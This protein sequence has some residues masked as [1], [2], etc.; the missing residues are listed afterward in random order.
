MADD[1]S[2]AASEESFSGDLRRLE[3]LRRR[4]PD[5]L[6]PSLR[7]LAGRAR[8]SHNTVD[9]WLSGRTFPADVD[10]LLTVVDDIAQAAA[11]TGAAG[12]DAALLDPR[13]WREQH[14]AVNRARVREAERARRGRLAAAALAEAETRARHSALADPP[15]RLDQW[16]AARLRVHPAVSGTGTHAPGFVLP[17]YVE[18]LHDRQ[19]RDVLRTAVTGHEVVLLV[20]RGGSCT[21]KTRAAYEAVRQVCSPAGWD[22]VLP[23]TAASARELLSARA[24]VARTVLW[25][26]D[27]HHLLSGSEG[28]ALSAGLL[29][30][31][32]RPGPA[33]IMATLWDAAYTELTAPPRDFGAA[34]PRRHA[35]DLLA[36]AT[37]VVHVPPAFGPDDL[38]VLDTLGGD[39]ALTAARSSS[40][41]GKITQ[42]LA[43]GLQLVDRYES[44][45]EPPACYPRALV[46]AAMDAS[47]LGWDALLPDGFLRDAAPG[48]LTAEQRTAAGPHWF[49]AALAD[50]RTQVQ[51]VAAALEPAPRP[52]GMGAEPGVSYLAD[53][54]DAHGRATR[55]HTDPP[56]SFWAAAAGHAKDPAVLARLSREAERRGFRD[57]AERLAGAATAAGDPSAY[58]ALA[59]VRERSGDRQ[60]AERMARLAAD[61]GDPR[62]YAALAW[63]R[64]RAGD[65][66]SAERMARLAFG[67]GSRNA[68]RDLTEMRERVGDRRGAERIARLAAGSGD[69]DALHRLAKGRERAGDREDAERLYA[70]AV[71]AGSRRAYTGLARTQERA[72]DHRSAEATAR[73]AAAAGNPRCYAALA[74]GRERAG[75]LEEAGRLYR[76]AFEAGDRR[77][78]RELTRMRERAGGGPGARPAAGPPPMAPPASASVPTAPDG[79]GL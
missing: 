76:L 43:A 45:H 32:A 17:T 1:N 54:L 31:L 62:C 46:T 72:G 4:L 71:G 39:P 11:G 70:L 37:A 60:G 52:G 51:R 29:S 42:T 50:A 5:G 12:G 58:A 25:L 36:G 2:A 33:I 16:T 59:E 7:V 68:L 35:R 47:R 63:M 34:D 9:N 48:Y 24:L 18:R 44:A 10:V 56:P 14:G 79:S 77:A 64:E 55:E 26:D 8:R 53:Y 15:R 74:K 69:P 61:S 19:L 73:L 49:R 22:L 38:Q 57:D 13:R 30:R 21:G 78:A 67:A 20:V 6:R 75:D 27:A 40:R 65:Q 28:E 23:H 66:R 3:E 41:D